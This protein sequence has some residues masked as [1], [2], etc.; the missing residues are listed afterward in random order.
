MVSVWAA[1]R[2]KHPSQI[3]SAGRRKVGP[4]ASGDRRRPDRPDCRARPCRHGEDTP[5]PPQPPA[6]GSG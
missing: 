5:P 3:Y 2:A 4:R 1:G 6:V